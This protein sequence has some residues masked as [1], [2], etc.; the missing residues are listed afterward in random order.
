MKLTCSNSYVLCTLHIQVDRGRRSFGVVP[1]KNPKSNDW[2]VD[3]WDLIDFCASEG[4]TP[5]V[6]LPSHTPVVPRR[7]PLESKVIR[8]YT[9][10]CTLHTAHCTIHTPHFTLHTSHCTLHTSYCTLHTAH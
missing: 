6:C 7:E 2:K 1:V 9:E 8:H 10:H 3:I 5:D 4:E